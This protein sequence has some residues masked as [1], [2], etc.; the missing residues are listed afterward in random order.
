[1]LTKKV[2]LNLYIQII[3]LVLKAYI[4]YFLFM[5][6]TVCPCFEQMHV[7]NIYVSKM[8]DLNCQKCVK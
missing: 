7:Y 2:Y 5:F 8:Y 1:M 4:T 6:M 3:K